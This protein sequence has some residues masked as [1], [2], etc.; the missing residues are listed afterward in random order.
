MK[1]NKATKRRPKAQPGRGE[2]K[3]GKAKSQSQSTNM[4]TNGPPEE[5]P[6]G[7]RLH[8]IRLLSKIDTKCGQYI[9]KNN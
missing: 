7:D 8:I 1:A 4:K 2:Q 6:P 9:V 3:R 5:P